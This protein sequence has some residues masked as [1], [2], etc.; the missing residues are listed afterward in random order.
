MYGVCDPGVKWNEVQKCSRKLFCDERNC[1]VKEWYDKK[2][3]YQVA[4]IIELK[5]DLYIRTLG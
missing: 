5:Y 2:K 3:M 1:K 4:D